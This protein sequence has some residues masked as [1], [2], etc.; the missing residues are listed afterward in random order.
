MSKKSHADH[1]DNLIMD[2]ALLTVSDWGYC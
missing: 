1:S 2:E